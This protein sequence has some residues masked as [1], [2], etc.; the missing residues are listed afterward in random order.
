[1]AV[2]NRVREFRKTSRLTQAE[3]GRACGVSRQSI[4]SVEGGDY[5]PSV[6]LALKLAGALDSTVEDLFPLTPDDRLEPEE[7]ST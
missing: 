2:M 4:V 6:Y 5:S 1:M 7:E 3:L